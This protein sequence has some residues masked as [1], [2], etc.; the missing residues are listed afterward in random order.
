LAK[1]GADKTATDIT[2]PPPLKAL[3]GWFS[4]EWFCPSV[5]TDDEVVGLTLPDLP[6]RKKQ[7]FRIVERSAAESP[8]GK[9]AKKSSVSQEGPAGRGIFPLLD[10]IGATHVAAFRRT[11]LIFESR[12]VLFFATIPLANLK[13]RTANRLRRA[14]MENRFRG[15]IVHTEASEAT[16]MFWPEAEIEITGFVG[17]AAPQHALHIEF[18]EAEEQHRAQAQEQ[19]FSLTRRAPPPPPPSPAKRL[20]ERERRRMQSE[21]QA[22]LQEIQSLRQQIGRMQDSQTELGAMEALGL[23]DARLKSMLRLLHPDKHGNSEAA[24]DAAKWLNNLR[25]LLKSKRA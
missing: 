22:L 17:A 1:A 15:C 20:D 2:I 6:G 4:A 24:N 11:T 16:A 12:P 9:R 5:V 21:K 23:D 14:L 25:D 18:D 7:S 8:A 3:G 13:L 19:R 10:W